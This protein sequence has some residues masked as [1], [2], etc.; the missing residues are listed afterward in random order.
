M[1]VV[2][3]LLVAAPPLLLG[4]LSVGACRERLLL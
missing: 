3:V 4:P 2:Y 1:S